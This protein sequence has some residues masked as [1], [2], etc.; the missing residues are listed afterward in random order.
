MLLWK[1]EIVIA[2][3]KVQSAVHI[4][5]G[6][7]GVS[8]H[9]PF[10]PL[11]ASLPFFFFLS[12]NVPQPSEAHSPVVSVAIHAFLTTCA[13]FPYYYFLKWQSISRVVNI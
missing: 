5:S 7:K 8:L 6:S 13:S 3:T 11:L 4:M 9:A 12:G 1:D 2:E 10:L